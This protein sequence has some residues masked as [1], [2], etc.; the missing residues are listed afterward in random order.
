MINYIVLNKMATY[1]NL[2]RDIFFKT[3]TMILSAKI[4]NHKVYTHHS[5]NIFMKTNR[6]V[7]ILPF[8]GLSIAFLQA[9]IFIATAI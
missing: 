5:T 3:S 7:E 1:G 9:K 6:W 8:V 2:K 4:N